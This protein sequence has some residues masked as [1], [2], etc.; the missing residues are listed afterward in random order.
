MR[1]T[2]PPKCIQ[3]R[4]IDP[5]PSGQEFRCHQ[6]FQLLLRV[7]W[8][9]EMLTTKV[10]SQKNVIVVLVD[11]CTNKTAVLPEI[12]Q[13]CHMFFLPP[14]L[15]LSLEKHVWLGYLPMIH[16][17]RRKRGDSKKSLPPVHVDS[18]SMTKL[19]VQYCV[20]YFRMPNGN[21]HLKIRAGQL[22][23]RVYIKKS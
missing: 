19:E 16:L 1:S 21:C 9:I 6:F 22:I 5:E 20:T 12:S 17:K 13:G 15:L 23:S 10:F 4:Q 14:S 11:S 2:L 7:L 8:A 18:D 3:I